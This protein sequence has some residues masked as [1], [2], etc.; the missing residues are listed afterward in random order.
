MRVEG[1]R[2]AVDVQS[3]FLL[4][5]LRK[6]FLS[7]LKHVC[8]E[9]IGPGFEVEFRLNENLFA[10]RPSEATSTAAQGSAA[11]AAAAEQEQEQQHQPQ[12]PGRPVLS[13]VGVAER[14]AG[15]GAL[16]PS[17]VARRGRSASPSARTGAAKTS[18]TKTI[19]FPSGRF[20]GF[21]PRRKLLSFEEFVVGDSNRLAATS[22]QLAVQRPGQ[23]T[24]LFLYG[25]TGVGKT[26]LLEA[27]LSASRRNGRR[28]NS[29]YLSAEQFTTM[30]L[31]AMNGRGLPSFRQKHRGVDVLIVD[32]VQFLLGKN[33][34]VTEL[35]YTVESLLR[36]GRQVIL[37]ADRAPAQL[38]RLGAE[39]VDRIRSGLVCGIEPPE[40][41]TRVGIVH[42]LCRRMQMELPEGVADT[43]AARVT[44]GAR[45]LAGALNRLHVTSLATGTP[46]SASLAETA[47]S[48]LAAESGGVVRLPDIQRAVCDVLGLE[49]DTLQSERKSKAV[50]YPRMLAM[51]LARKYTR[52][53][54]SEIGHYFGRRSHSTVI[55]AQRKVERWMHQ[56][57]AIDL[58]GGTWQVDDAIRQVEDRLQAG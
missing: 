22:A 56:R 29:V 17:A 49:P 47:L 46:I 8:N 36:G 28:L 43:V 41:A 24:P 27:V 9:V 53:A 13:G 38:T 52:A 34:T 10:T 37:A 26:H 54:L 39:L 55:S 33:A 19:R 18:E 3:G 16:A 21:Q 25:R 6:Q 35:R 44:G 20:T 11:M 7:E 2:L 32:D 50:S 51:F 30:F 15:A 45:D 42:N 58:A 4:E 1:T 14:Q 12:S 40:Y 31:E 23:S 48:A 5:C 57:Q